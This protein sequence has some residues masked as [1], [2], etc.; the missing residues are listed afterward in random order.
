MQIER[1]YEENMT[2]A[3]LF[4]SIKLG[5]TVKS[6]KEVTTAEEFEAHSSKLLKLAK[7]TVRTDLE[8]LKQELTE[9]QEGWR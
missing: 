8:N 3:K 1:Y 6:D 4:K 9:E 7:R 2:N 5:L